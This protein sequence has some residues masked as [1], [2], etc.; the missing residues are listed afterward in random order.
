MDAPPLRALEAL[1]L[2][3]NPI[4]DESV[5]A[6]TRAGQLEQVRTLELSYCGLGDEALVSLA[7]G[8]LE[9]LAN[10]SVVGNAISDHGVIALVSSMSAR[11]LHTLHVGP[12]QWSMAGIKALALSP[13]LRRLER[14]D[15]WRSDLTPEQAQL[16]AR[17]PYL[18]T[19]SA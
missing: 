4:G 16:L 1:A 12:R 13:R 6:L 15:T 5:A 17:S 10:L 19:A 2:G 18:P 7:M 3:S 14:L 8:R 11:R 9:A